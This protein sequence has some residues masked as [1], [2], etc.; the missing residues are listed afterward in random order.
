M[1]PH[2]LFTDAGRERLDEVQ[3]FFDELADH[4]LAGKARDELHERLDYL[5]SYG[6]SDDDGRRRF[7]VTL[8]RDWAPL[9]FTVAWH[10]LHRQSGA[11]QPAFHGALIWH[12][13]SNDPLSVTLTPCLWALHT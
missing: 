5:D 3:A 11:Y 7:Q 13:G 4:P 2:L 9:S 10:A 8:G 6:G 12:G 1:W